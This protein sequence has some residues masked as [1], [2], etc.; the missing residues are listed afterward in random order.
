M[1]RKRTTKKQKNKK[2]S[3]NGYLLV[4]VRAA[5]EKEFTEEADLKTRS[6]GHM[7]KGDNPFQGSAVEMI[8]G[9]QGVIIQ[10]KGKQIV[11]FEITVMI[12]ADEPD[13][14][15]AERIRIKLEDAG[16]TVVTWSKNAE[17]SLQLA[18]KT[19]RALRKLDCDNEWLSFSCLLSQKKFDNMPPELG[20]N[21]RDIF[22]TEEIPWRGHDN[23]EVVSAVFHAYAMKMQEE[24][25][26]TRR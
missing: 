19:E 26:R 4:L 5:L 13:I 9:K 25:E 12:E 16:F 1:K 7:G 17:I 10:Q 23:A 2:K 3:S 22:W 15:F 6:W 20:D 14:P 24:I 18:R 8:V 11:M 21:F